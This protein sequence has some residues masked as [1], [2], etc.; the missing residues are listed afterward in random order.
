MLTAFAAQ[1]RYETGDDD[2]AT[3]LEC[4]A[5]KWREK[6]RIACIRVELHGP[7]ELDEVARVWTGGLSGHSIVGYC[8]DVLKEPPSD[9]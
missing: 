9:N 6:A 8:H 1:V 3:M 2:F 4:A 5:N 7:E